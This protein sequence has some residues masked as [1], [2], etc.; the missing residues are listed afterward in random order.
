VASEVPITPS[1]AEAA[2][3]TPQEDAESKLLT[4][5]AAPLWPKTERPVTSTDVAKKPRSKKKPVANGQS[6][7]HSNQQSSE[8]GHMEV[9]PRLPPLPH[10]ELV[11]DGQSAGLAAQQ[12]TIEPFSVDAML[13]APHGDA[14]RLV[15]ICGDRSQVGED[16]TLGISNDSKI[17]NT[18]CNTT[19]SC[20][21][22]GNVSASAAAAWP[23]G[24]PSSDGGSRVHH[25]A[26]GRL[27]RRHTRH[28]LSMEC[29]TND[30]EGQGVSDSKEEPTASAYG[31]NGAH[32]LV[33]ACLLCACAAT[34]RWMAFH[35]GRH[36]RGF[37]LL[38][39]SDL[40]L[41]FSAG[42]AIPARLL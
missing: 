20:N 17:S 29:N 26:R 11:A 18:E 24:S 42:C 40:V 35:L 15:G 21:A 3:A 23:P 34:R 4:R 38:P 2:Q 12:N 22:N 36:H 33:G 30:Y 13:T 31:R 27:H 25:T 32:R 19:S 14:K 41:H 5:Q 10:T 37:G 9:R 7:G 6:R 8:F 28:T 1:R 39:D 16:K